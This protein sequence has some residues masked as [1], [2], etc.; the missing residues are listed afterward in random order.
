MGKNGNNNRYVPI[1]CE[2][3]MCGD[4]TVIYVRGEDYDKRYGQR[5]P[6]QECFPY[7]SVPEREAI[8]SGTCPVCQQRLFPRNYD[9]GD[10][11]I[12]TQRIP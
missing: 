8:I 1:A 3:R 6:V 12:G 4:V 11:W 2:C 7:L 5:C 9:D 10:N